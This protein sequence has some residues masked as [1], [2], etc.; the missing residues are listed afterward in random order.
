[1]LT[2][3]SKKKPV[4]VKNT[5]GVLFLRNNM[6]WWKHVSKVNFPICHLQLETSVLLKII[7]EVP[8]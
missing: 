4:K 2:S 8:A 6:L 5:C 3:K 1:M 7:S